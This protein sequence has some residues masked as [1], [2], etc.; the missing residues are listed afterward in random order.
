MH[1][2][3]Y[4]EGEREIYKPE[5]FFNIL[6]SFN[7]VYKDFKEKNPNYLII[8]LLNKLHEELNTAKNNLSNYNFNHYNNMN[9]VADRNGIINYGIN[10]FITTNYSIILNLFNWFEITENKCTKCSNNFYSFQ[11]FSTFDLNIS[12]YIIYKKEPNIKLEDCLDF[13]LNPEKLKSFVNIVINILK[14]Q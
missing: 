5:N 1:L 14:I 7:C 6:S 3:P 11:S 8:C 9:I 10:N 13:L 2:Y 12:N 4:P